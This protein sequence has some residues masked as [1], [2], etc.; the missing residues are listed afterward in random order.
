MAHISDAIPVALGYAIGLV[1]GA[2]VA[3]DDKHVHTATNVST[4]PT[5]WQGAEYQ[6]IFRGGLLVA[7]LLGKMVKLS[8]ATT[9][10]MLTA[11]AALLTSEAVR[12]L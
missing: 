4:P 5:F 3:E 12:A 11:S 10:T 6:T 9:D 1:D 8:D 2:I 7:A